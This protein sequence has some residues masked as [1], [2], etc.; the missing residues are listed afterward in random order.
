[1]HDPNLIVVRID[2][3]A[4]RPA[5]PTGRLAPGP[6]TPG[7]ATGRDGK[8]WSEAGRFAG[9]GQS[10]AAT[11]LASNSYLTSFSPN[12]ASIVPFIVSPSTLAL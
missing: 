9:G 11:R 6:L 2:P 1:M 5:I 7:R 10:L 12:L 8:G 4:G 3:R